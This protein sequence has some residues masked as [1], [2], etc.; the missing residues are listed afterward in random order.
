M[1][2]F[3]RG[4]GLEPQGEV[5][6]AW[7]STNIP[8]GDN[9]DGGNVF[10]WVNPKADEAIN[11]AGSTFDQATRKQAFCQLG[12]LIQ[13]DLVQVYLYLFQDGYGFNSKV[14]GYTVSTWGSMTWDVQ[15]WWLEQ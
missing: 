12:D 5:A 11:A 2:I 9:V 7:L 6:D 8:G 10:R 13:E 3:D 1:L 14:H 4:F 15:D